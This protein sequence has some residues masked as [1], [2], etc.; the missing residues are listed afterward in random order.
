[1]PE[2][3]STME[4]EAAGRSGGKRQSRDAKDAGR[5]LDPCHASR[6]SALLHTTAE[7]FPLARLLAIAPIRR[8]E[9]L[10]QGRPVR[11]LR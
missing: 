10:R 8:R 4:D 2:K 5:G 3:T 11:F 7:A 9:K 1:M 6:R